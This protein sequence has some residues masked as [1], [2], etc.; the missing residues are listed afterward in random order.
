[1]SRNPKLVFTVLA[2]A[3]TVGLTVASDIAFCWSCTTYQNSKP[4]WFPDFGQVCAYSGS[5]CRE[6]VSG[7]S[8]G[9]TVCVD[10]PQYPVCTDYP[11]H[12]D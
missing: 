7:G 3:A 8:G 12:R 11:D 6:C 1:M 10:D 5:S 9:Y 2:L 4:T